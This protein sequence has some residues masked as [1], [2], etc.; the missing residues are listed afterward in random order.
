[1]LKELAANGFQVEEAM[2]YCAGDET[3][4][5]EVLRAAYTEGIEKI[6]LLKACVEQRDFKRY[7]IEVHAIK[8]TAKTIGAS[9]LYNVAVRQNELA[10]AG[11]EERAYAGNDALVETYEKVL[12]VI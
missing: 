6:S 10:K 7:G 2:V 11:E 3:V 4:Y 1:M 12:N 9:E 5:H 8:S